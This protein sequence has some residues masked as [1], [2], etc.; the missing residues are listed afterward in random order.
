MKIKYLGT[1]ACEGIPSLYC[2]CFVCEN[3]RKKLGKEIRTRTGFIFD[4]KIA[5]DFSPDSFYNMIRHGIDFARIE[6]LLISHSHEDHF[7]PDDIVLRTPLHPEGVAP[8]LTLYGNDE[9]IKRFY[10]VR[11]INENTYKYVETKT[12]SC[13]HTYDIAG[14]SVTP[15]Y[16]EHMPD[17]NSM[18]FLI[19]KDNKAY[20]HLLDS[21]EP[22][23]KVYEF[24]QKN[25][26]VLNAVTFDCTFGSTKEEFYGHMNI[27]QNVRVRDKL[28]ADGNL[29]ENAPCVCS[30]VSHYNA[31]DSH[32][33]L[34]K[35]AEENGLILAYD[36]M[37]TEF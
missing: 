26:I 12:I 37:E 1:G 22:T 19:R 25:G 30:H 2:K 33:R 14:Y 9:V 27:R 17:E 18:I 11:F 6:H 7:Y 35:I 5:I 20:L 34:G 13:D 21:A 31:T 16:T 24:L 10:S 29:A 36:G 8:K 4:E 32:E 28:K 3:A 15:F 23:D